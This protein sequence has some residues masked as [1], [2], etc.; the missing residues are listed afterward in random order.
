MRAWTELEREFSGL[1]D[2]FQQ[3][4]LDH[5]FGAAGE[6]WRLAAAPAG[7]ARRFRTLARMAGLKLLETP[8]AD[9]WPE[10]VAEPDAERRWYQALRHI[11][12]AWRPEG[13][14]VQKDD[15]GS[16]AG[17]IYLGQIERP[18]EASATLCLQMETVAFTP[19]ISLD[20]LCAIPRYAGPCEHWRAVQA[21][22]ARTEP[23]LAGAVHEAVSAVEGLAR[24][25]LADETVTL[26]D[27]LKRFRERGL[28]HGALCKTL[29]GLFLMIAQEEQAIRKNPAS[30][31]GSLARKV[32]GAL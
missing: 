9:R 29:D 28:L 25:V 27:A 22:M 26:G 21:I 12:G 7:L 13:Y 6:H 18:F 3:A 5:Q 4:R 23:D 24:V 19:R 15:L 2:P 16:D 8:G 32:F 30:A 1:S 14:G 10:V 20:V 17:V 11:A 31:A